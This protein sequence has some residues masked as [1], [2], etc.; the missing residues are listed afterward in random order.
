[1]RL[2]PRAAAVTMIN[3]GYFTSRVQLDCQILVFIWSIISIILVMILFASRRFSLKVHLNCLCEMFSNAFFGCASDLFVQV[4]TSLLIHLM[5]F[6][7]SPKAKKKIKSCVRTHDLCENLYLNY[8]SAHASQ[9]DTASHKRGYL[10]ST[11]RPAL[12]ILL[13][14]PSLFAF[15]VLVAFLS[16]TIERRI[17]PVAAISF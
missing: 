13:F 11:S 7:H 14:P 10:D 4:Q 2:G 16:S 17:R 6:Q 3:L 8:S 9:F 15:F 1:M 12:R 5:R